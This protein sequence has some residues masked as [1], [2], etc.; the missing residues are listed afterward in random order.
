M[1]LV[2][3]LGKVQRLLYV[4]GELPRAH[5][6]QRAQVEGQWGR[7]THALRCHSDH[8]G[9]GDCAQAFSRMLGYRLLQA[10]AGRIAAVVRGEPAG[11]KTVPACR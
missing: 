9:A 5:L 4:Q 6:L 10:A 7:L 8:L 2:Q 1:R 3:G 11:E